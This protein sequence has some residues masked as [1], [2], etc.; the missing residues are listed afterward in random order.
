ML[1]SIRLSPNISTE[2]FQLLFTALKANAT[3]LRLKNKQKTF[4][5]RGMDKEAVA[6]IYDG[7]LLSH[8]KERNG[9]LCRDMDGP[10][11]GHTE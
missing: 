8:E 5:S 6:H 3:N 9:A 10:R 2:P 7:I 1:L 4:L 11:N